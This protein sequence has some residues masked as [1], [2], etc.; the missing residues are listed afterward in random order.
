VPV[1]ICTF[2][3]ELSN[4]QPTGT[5][6]PITK[7]PGASAEAIPQL[8]SLGVHVRIWLVMMD[9]DLFQRRLGPNLC[10][11][12]GVDDNPFQFVP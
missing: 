1:L 11:L 5:V 12:A 4:L 2:V 7:L 3:H 6:L 10:D 8:P 9:R